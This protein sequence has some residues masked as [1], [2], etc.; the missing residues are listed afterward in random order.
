M[1]FNLF[2]ESV[3]EIKVGFCRISKG[4]I[5]EEGG[6]RMFR[7]KGIGWVTVERIGNSLIVIMIFGF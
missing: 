3:I 5:G 4:W 1:R 7:I 2:R 6:L